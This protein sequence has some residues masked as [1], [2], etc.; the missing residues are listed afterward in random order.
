MN[1]KNYYNGKKVINLGIGCLPYFVF[2]LVLVIIRF[3][4]AKGK[5]WENE[6][7]D[8][9]VFI[10]WVG[11]GYMVITFLF[12][13]SNEPRKLSKVEVLSL[14]IDNHKKNIEKYI[15]TNGKFKEGNTTDNSEVL[16]YHLVELFNDQRELSYYKSRGL[17]FKSYSYSKKSDHEYRRKMLAEIIKNSGFHGYVFYGGLYEG[18]AYD[19]YYGIGECQAPGCHNQVTEKWH[20]LCYSCFRE[21]YY[22]R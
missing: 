6:F 17:T 19:V 9:L 3:F 7:L 11:I 21:Q 22:N 12:N 20:T 14:S 16:S 2:F 4:L 10:Y 15:D 13:K 1:Y 8:F 18:Q 5:T